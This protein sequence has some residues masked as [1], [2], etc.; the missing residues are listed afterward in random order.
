MQL[1]INTAE[2]YAVSIGGSV[3]LSI[4]SCIFLW[5]AGCLRMYGKFYFLKHLLYPQLPK[6]IPGRQQATRFDLL[7]F[8]A[9]LVGNILSM[10]INIRSKTDFL[11]RSAMTCIINLIPLALGAQMNII[12]SYC[13]IKLSTYSRIHRWLG[14]VTIFEGLIH[15]A[16]ARSLRKPDWHTLQDISGLAVSFHPWKRR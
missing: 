7:V 14:R 4:I 3:A 5:L 16:V 9:F 11:S 10:T 13:G 15:V 8:V 6:F 1:T 2:W 12:A